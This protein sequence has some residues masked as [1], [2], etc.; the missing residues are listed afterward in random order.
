MTDGNVKVDQLT[1][2]RRTEAAI[3]FATSEGEEVWIP[4]SLIDYMYTNDNTLLSY[5]EIPEWLA[6]NKDLD[7]ES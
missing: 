1:Q 3:L 2:V 6:K 5:I 7:Y 4:R